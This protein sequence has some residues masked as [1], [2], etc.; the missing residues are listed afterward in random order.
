MEYNRTHPAIISYGLYLYFSSRSLRLAAKCLESVIKR[1][2]V[3]IWKWVQKYSDYAN[4]FMTDRRLVKEI[5][6]DETLLRIDG[7]ERLLAMDSV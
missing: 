7:Q 2:H 5:F 3:S 4:R 6:V 1:S